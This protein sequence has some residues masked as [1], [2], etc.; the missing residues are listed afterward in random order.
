MKL[1]YIIILLA[2]IPATLLAQKVHIMSGNMHGMCNYSSAK[3]TGNQVDRIVLEENCMDNMTPIQ[4]ELPEPKPPTY[5]VKVVTQSLGPR[6]YLP[7]CVGGLNPRATNCAVTGS[8][9]GT[10]PIAVKYRTDPN[11][12]S[13]SIEIART[14]LRDDAS[15]FEAAV[16]LTPGNFNVPAKCKNKIASGGFTISVYDEKKLKSLPAAYQ[17]FYCPVQAGKVHYLTIRPT[18]PQCGKQVACRTQV[19]R[20]GLFLPYP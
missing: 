16:S 14:E 19:I 2:I 1:K 3:I 13:G 11:G 15:L 5:D 17:Q 6:T 18:N 9:Q 12:S 4:P 10:T 8:F 20:G 7:D